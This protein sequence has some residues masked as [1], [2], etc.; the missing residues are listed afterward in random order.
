LPQ[1]A[2]ARLLL[3]LAGATDD[4]PYSNSVDAAIGFVVGARPSRPDS[5]EA[6]LWLSGDVLAGRERLEWIAGSANEGAVLVG[7]DGRVTLSWTMLMKVAGVRD[8]GRADAALAIANYI[9]SD[10]GL[11]LLVQL[12][13]GAHRYRLHVA[14]QAPTQGGPIPVRAGVNLDNNYDS[15]INP[16][17]RTG[18]KLDTELPPRGYDALIGLNPEARWV[19]LETNR[20]VPAGNI[21]F[22]EL[23][24]AQAKVELGLD[25]LS[26]GPRPGAHDVAIEREWRLKAQR[27]ERRVVVTVGPNR[28][29]GSMEEEPAEVSLG[30]AKH[31]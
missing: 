7:N 31:K 28:V 30:G 14:H 20:L 25:Y 18:R 3:R 29:L 9:A 16:Y 21:A 19:N 17:R 26:Q 4:A 13:E 2:N 10:E 15:R 11:L 27:P 24:E 1:L 8:S 12:T 23:A 6:G 22:H 5:G